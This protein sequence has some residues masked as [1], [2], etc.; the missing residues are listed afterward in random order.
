MKISEFAALHHVSPDTV[1]YYIKEG[2]LYPI[3]DG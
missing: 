1:R 2:L 3:R